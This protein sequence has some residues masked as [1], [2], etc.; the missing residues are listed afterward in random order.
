MDLNINVYY[1]DR[2]HD[3]STTNLRKRVFKAEN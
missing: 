1:H 2:N 3:Y